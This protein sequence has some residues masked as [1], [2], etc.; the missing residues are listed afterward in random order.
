MDPCDISMCSHSKHICRVIEGVATC[1]CNEVCTM[2]LRP[3]CA[4][5]GKTYP[6]QCAMEVESCKTNQQLKVSSEGECG[7]FAR[8]CEISGAQVFKWLGL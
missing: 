7:M 4:S 1:I 6:N 5:N 2:D 3:V 8:S